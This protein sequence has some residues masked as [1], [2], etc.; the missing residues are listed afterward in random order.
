MERLEVVDYRTKVALEGLP[1]HLAKALLTEVPEANRKILVDFLADLVNGEN[2]SP[3]T[4]LMY[5]KHLLYLFK[6]VRHKPIGE[7]T[8]DDILS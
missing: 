1:G 8:R 2:K 7:I 3:N 5:A 6:S 4:K